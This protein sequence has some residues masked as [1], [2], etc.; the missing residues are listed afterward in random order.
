MSPSNWGPP[1]KIHGGRRIRR[2]NT[3]RR[4]GTHV[5]HYSLGG[6][7]FMIHEATISRPRGNIT[8]VTLRAR[9]KSPLVSLLITPL[10]HA[11]L[12]ICTSRHH[13]YRAL[14]RSYKPL[15]T[16]HLSRPLH[17]LC[18]LSVV[19]VGVMAETSQSPWSTNPNAPKIPHLQYLA[20]KE[21]FI[22]NLAGSIF[23]GTPNYASVIRTHLTWPIY[24]S[25]LC[26]RPVLPMHGRIT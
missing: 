18:L 22:G 13:N 4:K 25:R 7:A 5:C 14:T 3:G 6:L 23:Y 1:T 21:N 10:H 20:E 11:P 24:H 15:R 9:A 16:S 8:L 19:Q 2:D 26:H 17:Y 12:F